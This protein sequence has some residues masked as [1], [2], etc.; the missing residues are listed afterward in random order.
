MHLDLDR[1]NLRSPL[2]R[3]A[4]H[5]LLGAFD[6]HLHKVDL[7]PPV[8]GQEGVQRDRRRHGIAA[9]PRHVKSLLKAASAFV[10]HL[11]V[12]R[13]DRSLD[14]LAAIGPRSHV[15]AAQRRVIGIEFDADHACPRIQHSEVRHRHTDVGPQVQDRVRRHARRRKVVAA[16]E[17]VSHC[18]IV[19]R[20]LPH[21]DIAAECFH[22]NAVNSRRHRVAARG[23]ALNLGEAPRAGQTS[24]E[25][26]PPEEWRYFC[27]AGAKTVDHP[28]HD[29]AA[30]ARSGHKAG[31]SQT[32]LL[33][34]I[35]IDSSA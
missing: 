6:V 9:F 16:S 28:P 17:G 29:S 19:F 23:E 15:L 1:A 20:A 32:I 13:P 22:A 31:M 8:P 35:G 2:R 12:G 26:E 14:E 24:S 10:R 25:P 27:G 21:A 7:V 18:A 34:T 30:G 3:A 11:T 33:V 5:L 4:Q